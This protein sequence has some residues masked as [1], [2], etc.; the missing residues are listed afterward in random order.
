M[1]HYHYLLSF[2]LEGV[3]PHEYD[4]IKYSLFTGLL[5]G[6]VTSRFEYFVASTVSFASSLNPQQMA[7]ILDRINNEIFPPGRIIRYVLA[8]INGT[9]VF[10]N[11]NTDQEAAF[12]QALASR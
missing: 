8:E 7:A 11:K 5:Q 2:D 10:M 3:E 9:S 4:D 6:A 12:N 1:S